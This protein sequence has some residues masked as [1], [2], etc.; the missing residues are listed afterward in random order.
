MKYNE[1]VEKLQDKVKVEDKVVNILGTEIKVKQYLPINDAI[2]FVQIAIQEARE[3]RELNQVKLDMYFQLYMVYF[4]S[5]IEFSDEDKADPYT[6]YDNLCK[7]GVIDKVITAIPKD[8]YNCLFNWFNQSVGAEIRSAN[9]IVPAIDRWVDQLPKQM[10]QVGEIINN[11]DPAK[12]QNVVDFAT[13][14]NGGR[15]INTNQPVEE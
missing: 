14:A 4:F 15:N 2:D 6:T 7:L 3:G 1:L 5:D 11:F 13:A 8:Q 10:E 9:S 12:Y